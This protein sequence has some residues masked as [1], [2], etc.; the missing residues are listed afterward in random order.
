MPY[1]TPRLSPVWKLFVSDK[2]PEDAPASVTTRIDSYALPSGEVL[3]PIDVVLE[4]EWVNLAAAA[5]GFVADTTCGLL[6]G[7]LNADSDGTALYGAGADWWWNC[8]VNGE[9]VFDRGRNANANNVLGIFSKFDWIFPVRLRKGANMIAF[10]IHA[11]QRWSIGTGVIPVPKKLAE[12]QVLED[13]GQET[14]DEKPSVPISCAVTPAYDAMRGVTLVGETTRNP[15]AYHVGEDIEFVFH[16]NDPCASTSGRMIILVWQRRGD[17]GVSAS[18]AEIISPTQPV[19]ISTSLSRPGFVHISA[20]AVPVPSMDDA[21]P[22]LRFEGGAGAD[23]GA[24]VPV[25]SRPDDF[26]EFWAR[27]RKLLDAVP[28]EPE[29]HVWLGSTFPDGVKI[30]DSLRMILVKVPCAGPN[31]VT[32]FLAVPKAP[33]K[34]PVRVIFDGYGKEPK[35]SHRLMTEGM[36][37]FHVNAHGYDLFRDKAYY[38]A[39]F[40][41]FER[42]GFGYGISP[43][44]NRDPETAYFRG[45]ALRVMRAFDFAKTIPEWNGRDLIATGGSQG[46]LQAVWAASLVPGI[47][48]C[49]TWITW[50]SNMSGAALDGRLPG[51]HPEYVRGL[52]YYDTVFHAARIPVTCFVDFQR[53]GLG[54]YTCPPSGI[55]MV[56]NAVRGPK[57]AAYYQNSTHPYV[58]PEPSTFRIAEDGWPMTATC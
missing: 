16:L 2:I 15:I 20:H 50:C 47:T 13:D 56:Y 42:N 49:E 10:H 53:I 33:G 9:K 30:P 29:T 4:G 58:P 51:W 19:R 24:L 46:G 43:K 57:R 14:Q 7:I 31:P 8:F 21:G 5:G 40:A 38:D 35:L 27:Q 18:G 17:D 1:I 37:T 44:E 23:I 32:G 26:D 12:S 36:I 22:E 48:C 39:F 55:T 28:L 3:K 45:M 11:G 6:V 25:A 41:P 54:D 52:D 34:Y